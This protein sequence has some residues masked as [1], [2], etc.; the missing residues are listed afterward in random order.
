MASIVSIQPALSSG[1]L[2]PSLRSRI[3]LD[4]YAIGCSTVR[5]FY[6]D[7]RGG[8]VSRP[9]LAYVGTC[10]QT[11]DI[12]PRDIPFQF[13]ITQ[14][15]V[16]EFGDYYMRIKYRGA[17][18][19]EN[20]VSVAS[21]NSS[22]L[23]TTSGAHGY[24]VGD[25]V[26]DSGN[27]GFNGLTWIIA[28]VPSGT[29]F[30]VTDLFGNPVTSATPSTGG[31]VSR[32]YTVVSPY[33][34]V[35]LPWLK[36]TQSADVMT[37][38]CVNFDTGTEYPPYDL[39]RLANDNWV[40]TE[41]SFAAQITAPTDLKAIAYSSDVVTTWYSYVVTA[42]SE[43][44]GEE[45]VAS[46][47]VNVQNNDISVSA[48]SNVITWNAVEGA[49]S[50]NVYAATP[51]YAT[52][53]PVS[54]LYGFVGI[55]TGP[56]FTDTNITPDF[57]TVPPTHND[58]FARGAIIDVVQDTQ[59]ENYSPS[60]SSYTITTSTGSGFQGT[61]VISTSPYS[62]GSP[63]G[64]ITG[65][66]IN[67]KG[68]GYQTG[69]TITYS[70]TGGGV[71]T[72]YIEASTPPVD[73]D[74]W[75]FNG[76]DYTWR[77]DPNSGN[78]VHVE[79]TS[80]LC[81]AN[82]ANVLNAATNYSVSLAT[83]VGSGN[84]TYVIYKTP[85][86]EGNSYTL[87][88]ATP[89]GPNLTGGG[90]IGSGATA[91]LVVGPNSGTYPSVAAYYQ[92]RRIYASSLNQPD[93]YWMTKPGLFNNMDSSI[94]TTD[95]D[96]ITGTPWAQQVNGINW[97]V[98]M[99]GGLVVLTGKGAWQLNGGNSAAITPSNQVATA[100]AYNGCN[101]LVPPIP[102]NYDILYVQAKGSIVRD[103]AYNFFTNIYT[104]TDM[105]VLSNHLFD[106]NSIVQWA[107]AEEPFKLIWVV[108]DDGK[109]LCLTYIKEQDVYSWTR[110]DTNGLFV[111]VCSVT[112]PPV[113]AVYVITKR[114]V[115]G[116]WRY[117][118]ERFNDRLWE[119][120]YDSFCVDSG[121]A[122]PATY[123]SATLT[124]SA[125]TGTGVTFTASSSVF[126]SSNVGDVIRVGGGIA[127]VVSYVSG[128]E[129]ICDI[130]RPITTTV[131]NNPQNMPV[132][133]Q[134]GS[135][136]IQTPTT[137]VSG[138]NHL[139]G[140]EV[141]ILADGSVV[142]NQTVTNGSIT[143][144]APCTTI[145]VGLPYICQAQT[146]P[147]NIGSRD[148]TVQGKRSTI[149]SV[150]IKLEY[151]RG[152]Q[153]GADEP[154]ASMQ[155]NQAEVPWTDLVEIKDRNMFTNAGSAVPLFSG[156][157]FQN[158][159]SSWNIESQVAIQQSYPLPAT[160]LGIVSFWVVGDDRA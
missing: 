145:V 104:G 148:Q 11:G 25:W 126:T 150:A 20:A 129:I 55:A 136:L 157:I 99:P 117:Y 149:N 3:D 138:L 47:P 154:D 58:P 102:I 32:I 86:T 26:F 110:H 106:Y 66:I 17:Y 133:A 111:S 139:E 128:T 114:Y 153:V 101:N 50:Y 159:S 12:P 152:I 2:S 71:A 90:T 13:S 70:D 59:G 14:G 83:Y 9:G 89:S 122:Y 78:A 5:N 15:Y 33:A 124:P 63:G 144:P 115:Q 118:S 121:L 98:P 91:H 127:T 10:K 57:T 105:T 79:A 27:S 82:M 156:E 88:G 61:L 62:V 43:S 6:V 37:L 76:Q 46:I 137:T 146:E 151:T 56:I 52:S 72:G 97:L 74:N 112:E 31:S 4:K 130:T 93:T 28:S 77:N 94:P 16:L 109:M 103:L 84:R 42:I 80:T 155:Q 95:S 38:C 143:L 107:W 92:Q 108:R 120:V 116:A 160:I 51:S 119:D 41:E 7:Y 18:V 49:S 44:T 147:L 134:S 68:S 135:W 29:T 8:L 65:M 53:A 60:T 131:P 75:L 22:G 67:N 39:E 125:A 100:Q 19:T 1:E 132:P 24:S 64:Q 23:F 69:D 34:A 140:L 85:G 87:S 123:P 73:G 30:T 48:G 40:F 21:I 35:D 54:S 45:S 96:S 142:P 141:A 113:D 81:C 158:V 36:Y